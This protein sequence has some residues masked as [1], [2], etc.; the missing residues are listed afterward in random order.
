MH[1]RP[2]LEKQIQRAVLDFLRYKRIFCWKQHNAGIQKANGRYIPAG[3]VG[4]SDIMGVMPDG[5]FLAVEIKR[6]GGKVSPSQQIFLDNVRRNR[7]LAWVVQSI[8]E[9]EDLLNN[10][11][12]GKEESPAGIG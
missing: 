2:P 4:V 7:G 9:A 8:K 10:Y 11:G 3:M 6:P 12:A 5:R 1:Q